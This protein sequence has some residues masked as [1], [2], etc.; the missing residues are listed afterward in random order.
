MPIF[1]P[2]FDLMNDD[3]WHPYPEQKPPECTCA[4]TYLVCKIGYQ[5]G[6]KVLIVRTNDWM[7]YEETVPECGWLFPD[8]VKFWKRMPE[9]PEWE[10]DDAE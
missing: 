9:P 10:E 6:K 4:R 1:D 2:Q 3:I 7:P 5:R 8:G